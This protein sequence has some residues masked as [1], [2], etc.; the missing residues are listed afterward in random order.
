M[1]K[2][3]F[4]KTALSSKSRAE[5][6]PEWTETGPEILV[7]QYFQD[8]FAC[9]KPGL[10]FIVR[11]PVK[12]LRMLGA[13]RRL[14]RLEVV[15]SF[16]DIEA[17]AIHGPLARHTI[18]AR[19]G[20]S[21][22]TVLPL[23]QEPGQYS[24]GASKQ[25]LRRKVRHARRQGVTWAEVTDVAERKELLQTADEF[26]RTHPNETYR[27]LSPDNSELLDYRLWLAAYSADG[28]PLLLSVTPFDDELALL[29]YF[30]T[31]GTGDEQSNA[32]YLMTQTLVDQLARRGVRYLLDSGSVAMPSGLR[33][34]QRMLGFRIV[35][36]RTANSARSAQRR[37]SHYR[38]PPQLG[39]QGNPV[40]RARPQ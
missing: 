21:V 18:L 22:A 8:Y 28:R 29:T 39:R 19:S 35:R 20:L 6:L 24:L 37:Q 31:M 12:S 1:I 14:P 25:T 2:L 26:E 13:L 36:I 11:K 40:H 4:A 23:P 33:H 30:R 9:G 7:S 10:R 5:R 34:F 27:N 15:P 17:A 3:P 38:R 16:A 32:R